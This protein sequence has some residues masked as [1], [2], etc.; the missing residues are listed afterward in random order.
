MSLLRQGADPIEGVKFEEKAINHYQ[1]ALLYFT[2][3]T[4]PK[5]HS[6]LNINL[7]AVYN[8]LSSFNIESL[9]NSKKALNA[10]KRAYVG[11]DII[12]H[13]EKNRKFIGLIKIHE[14]SAFQ[15][16]ATY[17]KGRV[18]I[19]LSRNAINSFEEAFAILDPTIFPK[20]Y[21]DAQINLGNAYSTLAEALKPTDPVREEYC[22]KS[23]RNLN[24]TLRVYSLDTDPFKYALIHL[25]LIN[26][27][28][29]R[30]DVLLDKPPYQEQIK[31]IEGI[32]DTAIEASKEAEKVYTKT[33]Y[34][35]HYAYTLANKGW[36]YGVLAKA[37]NEPEACIETLNAF[38]KAAEVL[39]PKEKYPQEYRLMKW[40]LR[41]YCNIYSFEDI[42]IFRNEW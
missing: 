28:R 21:T 9:I 17:R 3:E 26:A 38:Q 18:K 42:F 30:A 40:I 24:D 37:I 32:I 20:E 7:A 14:G 33:K 4:F 16:I 31:Q 29:V 1:E 6:F 11:L 19:N 22:N 35:R 34:P 39:I 41:K 8:V 2:V 36:A 27:Y 12:K 10:C 5:E 23:I 15:K 25:N 13:D